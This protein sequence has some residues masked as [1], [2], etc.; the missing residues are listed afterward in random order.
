[1]LLSHIIGYLYNQKDSLTAKVKL[2]RKVLMI[3]WRLVK[4]G[5]GNY[6]D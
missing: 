2:Y 3:K 5:A 1:M 6:R 4:G